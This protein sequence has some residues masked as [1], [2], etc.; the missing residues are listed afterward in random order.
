MATFSSQQ[1]A[2][3]SA[4][5]TRKIIAGAGAGKTTV[6]VEA[7]RRAVE[8]GVAPANILAVTFTR[9]AGEH[10]RSKLSEAGVVGVWAGTIHSWAYI[11]LRRWG[12][13]FTI[14]DES[15]LE[16]I[17][18]MVAEQRGL[19]WASR[20]S[21]Q[22]V[23]AIYRAAARLAPG[24]RKVNLDAK[25]QLITQWVAAYID[26]RRLVPVDHVLRR[27]LHRA[28][29]DQRFLAGCRSAARFL[30]WDEFQDS[31]P[32]ELEILDVLRQSNSLVIG[33]V[34]QAIYGFRGGRS[35]N[36]AMLPAE[37]VCSLTESWRCSEAVL[38]VA[39]A[40]AGPGF[41]PMV[42]ALAKPD[43]VSWCPAEAKDQLLSPLTFDTYAEFIRS[44]P[45]PVAVLCRTNREV[46]EAT[47]MLSLSY[48]DF[49]TRSLASDGDRYATG[50]WRMASYVVRFALDPD[51]DWAAYRC[52]RF[53]EDED[54]GYRRVPLDNE[55]VRADLVIRQ[56]SYAAFL[57]RTGQLPS[58]MQEFVSASA[59]DVRNRPVTNIFRQVR[60]L[61]PLC[62]DP[63]V[64]TMTASEFAAWYSRRDLQDQ[65]QEAQADVTVM[66]A[67]AAKG[68]EFPSVIVHGAGI[69][70]PMRFGEHFDAEDER[71]V[72]YVAITRA[73]AALLISGKDG[74]LLNFRRRDS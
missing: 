21:K 31:S 60:T 33:D 58:V 72:L 67:H 54:F 17:V 4:T 69:C 62:S 42:A 50:P 35:A 66:T 71:N 45:K 61:A 23:E 40:C 47:R 44:M 24:G 26:Q 28:K 11:T 18:H 49:V 8:S 9:R 56:E 48:P 41:P 64:S 43:L 2:A 1:L 59:D 70:Y 5:G 29:A 30:L 10:L 27:W 20:P 36:L 12:D 74:P 68:L 52:H 16:D 3:L 34:R 51:C 32:E 55:S 39:N 14:V 46:S 22:R 37:S 7:I 19:Y 57:A 38:S 25:E 53:L 15:D 65:Y 6:L 73:I 13:R 63:V